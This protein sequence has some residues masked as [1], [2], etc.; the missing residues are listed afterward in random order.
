MKDLIHLSDD[1]LV[2][3]TRRGKRAAFSELV[4][5][6][7]RAVT[8]LIHQRLRDVHRTL[9]VSQEVFLKVYRN[10]PRYEQRGRFRAW[11]LK[12]AANASLD[13]LREKRPRSI[14]YLEQIR[15][16]APSASETLEIRERRQAVQDT[17]D[18]IEE[19]FRVPL[20][21]R[22][23]EGLS[24]EEI[25]EVLGV[26]IGTVKSRV[27]RGR[28]RFRAKYLIRQARS[29]RAHREVESGGVT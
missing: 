2:E 17:L 13:A 26:A 8:G 5:R 20:A 24:Y 1:V 3:M 22:D 28:E 9:D 27:H 14:V 11:V 25:A 15:G 23:I 6:H 19:T 4:R 12:I 18:D 10:L 29:E 16:H 21:L 7:K